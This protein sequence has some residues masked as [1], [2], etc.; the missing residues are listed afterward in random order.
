M[1]GATLV[2]ILVCHLGDAIE[3]LPEVPFLKDHTKVLEEQRTAAW[4]AAIEAFDGD[5]SL[6]ESWMHQPIKV[7]RNEKPIDFMNSLERICI[8]R[9]IIAKLEHGFP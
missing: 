7:L 1:W 5:A 2:D 6:A 8:L 3:S 4:N 9:E